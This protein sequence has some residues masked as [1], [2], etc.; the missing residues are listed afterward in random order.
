MIK[1]SHSTKR[2]GKNAPTWLESESV[3]PKKGKQMIQARTG[4]QKHVAWV[5]YHKCQ[6]LSGSYWCPTFSG[7]KQSSEFGQFFWGERGGA[8]PPAAIRGNW[9]ASE[10][11]NWWAHPPNWSIVGSHLRFTLFYP[12][13]RQDWQ[14]LSTP[15]Q[16]L[17]NDEIESWFMNI[18]GADLFCIINK[19]F[20]CMWL[21]FC[22]SCWVWNL[23]ESVKTD[24]LLIKGAKTGQN[25][26]RTEKKTRKQ[27]SRLISTELITDD[28]L[29]AYL[30]PSLKFNL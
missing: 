8:P 25:R 15:T 23:I 3:T 27:N 2:K 26:W 19:A 20:S 30:F 17:Y 28:N 13:R 4:I 12:Q 1:R 6:W 5:S 9:D 22:N 11:G 14:L 16:T 18:V 21:K 7:W 24:H 10:I 29:F